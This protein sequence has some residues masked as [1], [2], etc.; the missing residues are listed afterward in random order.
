MDA[1]WSRKREG[2]IVRKI[3]TQ[4]DLDRAVQNTFAACEV[5][6]NTTA[7]AAYGHGQ[8]IGAAMGRLDLEREQK[9]AFEEEQNRLAAVTD[10][11]ESL[12]GVDPEAVLLAYTPKGGKE[13]ILHLKVKTINWLLDYYGQAVDMLKAGG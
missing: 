2:N 12:Q 3:Y 8:K 6:R 7:D 13:G 10:M 11:I 9:A 5:S 4:E 1:R